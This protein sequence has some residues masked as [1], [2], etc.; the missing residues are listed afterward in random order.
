MWRGELT[1]EIEIAA[2]RADL[3][4]KE[5]LGQSPF[6]GDAE[7]VLECVNSPRDIIYVA[8]PNRITGANFSLSDLEEMCQMTSEGLL[9]VDEYYIDLYGITAR[10]LLERFNNVVILRSYT[11]A[12]GISTADSGFLIADSKLISK[13]SEAATVG[14]FSSAIS[15]SIETALVN[16]TVLS[17]RLDEI[18]DESLRLATALRR[19]GLQSRITATDFVLLRVADTGA[20][21][22]YLARCRIAI[23]N[24]DGY[25][26]MSNYMRYRLQSPLTND[27]LIESFGKMSPELFRMKT[28]DR[29][30]TR[31]RRP[32]TSNSSD[33]IAQKRT[34]DR[35]IS[36]LEVSP[37]V[38][39][40]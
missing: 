23:E 28:I 6:V 19:L 26:Q 16:E 33:E 31:L 17:A 35:S 36:A 34:V 3:P 11:A 29:R 24:L 37:V 8:N 21:G 4:V 10:S 9:I 18:H 22:N 12:Y 7:K 40:E 27:R 38:E 32:G 15:K 14:H 25:P 2:D 13:I 20:V 30:D 39:R 1:P 5:I